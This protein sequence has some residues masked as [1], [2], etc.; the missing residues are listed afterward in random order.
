MLIDV[1]G[2]GSLRVKLCIPSI[3]PAMRSTSPTIR[4]ESAAALV[5][6]PFP[7]NCA[8]PRM[9]ESGFLI[10]CASIAAIAPAERAA[11]PGRRK[12]MRPVAG[13]GW[14]ASTRHAPS[15]PMGPS[16]MSA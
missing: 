13:T 11:E 10:S 2:G 1:R 12:G 15:L 8:A 4:R 3:N 5:E 9:P 7:S 6:P 14:S 16:A